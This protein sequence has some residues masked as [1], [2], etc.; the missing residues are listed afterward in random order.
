MGGSEAVSEEVSPPWKPSLLPFP[1]ILLEPASLLATSGPTSAEQVFTVPQGSPQGSQEE[2]K[3]PPTQ[4]AGLPQSCLHKGATLHSRVLYAFR[5]CRSTFLTQAVFNPNWINP[6]Q[7]HFKDPPLGL[8]HPLEHK[9]P[10]WTPPASFWALCS[11]DHQHGSPLVPLCHSGESTHPL[12]GGV[13]QRSSSLWPSRAKA[14][15]TFPPGG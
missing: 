5:I 9:I 10:T 3:T 13:G 8:R 14:D 12:Q 4:G 7:T 1:L 11:C 2:M 15:L 6:M